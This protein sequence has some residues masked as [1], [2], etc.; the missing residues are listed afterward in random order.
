MT[1]AATLG[2]KERELIAL[3]GG[4]GKSTLL[5][6][7]GAELAGAGSNVILTTTTKMGRF[8]IAANHRVCL[9]ADP[10]CFH[11]AWAAGDPALLLTGGDEHK[12]TGPTPEAVDDLFFLPAV[13]YIVVEA[14]GSHGMPLK[15]PAPYEPVIPEASTLVVILLGIDAVGRPLADVVHRLAEARQLS[16]LS[17]D[18]LMTPED[19]A[20]ILLHSDGLLGRSPSSARTTIA[21]TKVATSE[22]AAAAARIAD[23]VADRHPDVATL[24][25]GSSDP[26]EPISR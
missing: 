16:G 26:D 5:F 10:E 20:G 23:M 24:V 22:E 4:G 6:A 2:L 15:A 17:P 9:T 25:F 19:C 8:Q 14:D 18:H 11:S 13:D 12:V 1:L 21:L 7:L 3:V